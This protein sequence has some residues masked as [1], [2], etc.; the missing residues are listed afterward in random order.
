MSLVDLGKKLLDASRNGD[1]EEVRSLINSGAPFTTDWVSYLSFLGISPLHFSAM[2]GHLT[3]CEALLSA[4]ISRDARTKVDRT[5]LH[6]AAQEGHADIVE[7]LLKNGADLEAVDTLKMTA[8]HWAAE[9]G[10]Y[11][12]VQ[13]LM[14]YGANLSLQNKFEMTPLEIA[15]FHG[16]V[17]AKD[18]MLTTQVEVNSAVGKMAAPNED[19][20]D[21]NAFIITDEETVIPAA[22][23]ADEVIISSAKVECKSE[24]ISDVVPDPLLTE[25]S[26]EILIDWVASGVVEKADPDT[27][28][29]SFPS[30]TPTDQYFGQSIKVESAPFDS[31]LMDSFAFPFQGSEHTNTPLHSAPTSNDNMLLVETPEGTLLYVRQEEDCINGTKISIFSKDGEPIEDE[32]LLNQVAVALADYPV[33]DDVENNLLEGDLTDPLE[34]DKLAEKLGM[35]RRVLPLSEEEA[36]F[37][38]AVDKEALLSQLIQFASDG[39]RMGSSLCVD[40]VAYLPT[41]KALTSWCNSYGLTVAEFVSFKQFTVSFFYEGSDFF[42][43]ASYDSDYGSITF[44]NQTSL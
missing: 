43:R 21:P 10:H 29:T 8:L 13:V 41:E 32:T 18:A 6:L 2:N 42:L 15:E 39:E 33:Q 26:K 14:R 17:E 19:L 37:E 27:S 12:V 16:H 22:P 38:Y 34:A 31:Q 11:P 36:E 7:L 44:S 35:P 25:D 1:V 9:R 5:P 3:T 20:A 28:Q 40:G 30:L 4:G 23:P 24:Q